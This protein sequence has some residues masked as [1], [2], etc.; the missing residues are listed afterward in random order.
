MGNSD[1]YRISVI[2]EIWLLHTD[3]MKLFKCVMDVTFVN[4]NHSIHIYLSFTLSIFSGHGWATTRLRKDYFW[5]CW[6]CD[7]Q[8]WFHERDISSKEETWNRRTTTRQQ[9]CDLWYPGTRGRGSG[10]WSLRTHFKY[11]MHNFL[12][13][14]WIAI[15]SF[16]IRTFRISFSFQVQVFKNST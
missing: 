8:P 9:W 5:Y 12:L 16:F 13:G 14:W 6:K 10:K 3:S 11:P 4:F 15:L 2:L 7:G 1:K